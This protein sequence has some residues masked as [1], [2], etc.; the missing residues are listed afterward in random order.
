MGIAEAAICRA[1]TLLH[2][3]PRQY[4]VVHDI[5]RRPEHDPVVLN[6][7]QGRSG[8]LNAIHHQQGRTAD[9]LPVPS[10][11]E[12]VLRNTDEDKPCQLCVRFGDEG[13]FQGIDA[14]GGVLVCLTKCL[15]D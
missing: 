12:Y 2:K 6:D 11:R 15:G 10:L 13:A 1:T 5:L 4:E 9:G 7:K 14:E 8:I 3:F